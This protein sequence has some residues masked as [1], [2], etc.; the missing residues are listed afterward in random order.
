MPAAVVLAVAGAT[1]ITATIGGAIGAAIVGSTVSTVAATA[2]GTAVLSGT[3]TA[4][5]GGKVSDVLKSAVIGGITSYVGGT[6][7]KDIASDVAFNAISQGVGGQTAVIMGNA[8]GGAAAGA[9]SSGISALIN[10]RD[11][12]QA[13][14]KGGLT[15]GLSSAVNSSV[16]EATK[17]IPILSDPKNA[18]EGAF[19]RATKTAIAT[20][21]LGGNVKNAVTESVITSLG[22]MGFNYIKNAIKDNSAQVQT[23]AN[24]VK[25]A[26]LQLNNNLAAQQ[27][28]AWK[29]DGTLNNTKIPY[30]VAKN[31]ETTYNEAIEA[32]NNFVTDPVAYY[33]QKGAEVYVHPRTNTL[34]YRYPDGY[35]GAVESDRFYL[36]RAVEVSKINAEYYYNEAVKNY[37]AT[38]PKLDEYAAKL[39]ELKN[40]YPGLYDNYKN[41]AGGL[42]QAI[43]DFKAQEVKNSSIALKAM[44]DIAVAKNLFKEQEGREPTDAELA[45]YA[46]N[47]DLVGNI[48]RAKTTSNEAV[49]IWEGIFGTTPTQEEINAIAGLNEASASTTARSIY[50]DRSKVDSTELDDFIR[51]I[52]GGNISYTKDERDSL[53]GM[54]EA[55]A[56]AKI[57]TDYN[58]YITDKQTTDSEELESF[59]Q[60]VTKGQM[61]FTPDQ[62]ME[63]FGLPE[64]VAQSRLTNIYN[65]FVADK[66][67]TDGEEATA[68]WDKSGIDRPM[69]SDELQMMM[70]GSEAAAETYAQR[71]SEI[72]SV[73]PLDDPFANQA[74]AELAAKDAGFKDY[75]Y[76]G[77]TY[78]V[79]NNNI[80]ATVD[81]SLQ[82]EATRLISGA[83]E[84]KGMRLS[85]AAPEEIEQLV[86]SVHA[87]YGN[88]VGRLKA[89]SI[90][91]F[92]N[93][94]A[95]SLDEIQSSYTT[96][97]GFKVEIRG[98]PIGD[99]LSE[100]DIKNEAIKLLPAGLRLATEEETFDSGQ[101]S[102]ITLAN[103]KTAWV[104][105]KP[106]DE[107]PDELDIIAPNLGTLAPDD[108]S[109]ADPAAYIYTL[110]KFDPNKSNL[111]DSILNAAKQ[112]VNLINSSNASPKTRENILDAVAVTLQGTAE[113][114]KLFS[115]AVWATG[116]VNRDN[117]AARIA[118]AVGKY[119]ASLQ[120][121][122]TQKQEEN[123]LKAISDAKGAWN[124]IGAT[125]KA[126]VQNP[127]GALT[128]IGK[129]AVQEIPILA[130]S[131][132]VGRLVLGLGGKALAYSAAMGTSA[133]L[134]A[135]ESF[136]SGYG[137]T[138]DNI[139]KAGGTDEYAKAQAYKSGFQSALVGA[140]SSMLGDSAL[141]KKFMGEM[142]NLTLPTFAKEVTKQYATEWGEEFLTNASTQYN[143]YGTVNWEQAR[144]AGAIGG[145]M[146]AGISGGILAPNAINYQL[147]VAR[148]LQGNP[149]TLQQVVDGTTQVDPNSID[150]AAPVFNIN[151]VGVSIDGFTKVA[152]TAISQPDFSFTSYSNSLK[153][154]YDTGF[155]DSDVS[156]IALQ[157]SIAPDANTLNTQLQS[158][159]LTPVEALTAANIK[160][161]DQVTTQ[162]EVQSEFNQYGYFNP[163]AQTIESFAGVNGDQNLSN[164]IS[165]YVDRNYTD[166]EEVKEAAAREGVTL[167]NE[168]AEQYV[169]QGDQTAAQTS[170]QQAVDPMA[171]NLE[172]ARQ[173]LID[174]GYTPELAEQAASQFVGETP[175]A[176]TTTKAQE[177]V[178]ER[179]ITFE[180]AREYLTSLGYQPT[181]EEVQQFVRVAADPLTEAV[182]QEVGAYVEPRFV[183]EQEVRDAYASLGLQRPTQQ[184]IAKLVGQYAETDLAGKTETNLDAARYNSIIEQLNELSVNANQET[185]DAV[186]AIKNDLNSQLE[187]LGVDVN[188]LTGNVE[189]IRTDLTAAIQAARDAGL[190]GD[191]A[192]QQA[193]ETVA[194]DQNTSKLELLTRL[195]TTEAA[196][197]TQFASEIGAVAAEIGNVEGRLRDAIE[198]AEA[199]GLT[200]DQAIQAGLDAVAS[201]LGTTRNDLLAQLGTSEAALKAQIAQTETSLGE[202]IVNVR[203]QLSDAIA[204]AE[205][206]GLSRDEAIQAGV[207]A[208]ASDLGI[209][210]DTLL[211]QLGT[212]EAALRAEITA[213]QTALGEQ[214]TSGL[215]GVRTDLANAEARINQRAAEYESLGL[216]RDQALNAA[217]SD[218]ASQLGVTARNLEE[219]IFAAQTE[220]S[221]QIT[222]S[223]TALQQQIDQ[224]A[225]IL[226]KPARNVTQADL[227][228]VNSVIQLTPTTYTPEQLVYDVNKDA[229]VDEEDLDILTRIM[230]PTTGEPPV[231]PEGTAF[232]PTGL[233]GEISGLRT[234]I[235]GQLQQMEQRRQQEAAAAEAARQAEATAAAQ[236]AAQAQA[237]AQARAQQQRQYANVQQLQNMLLQPGALTQKVDVRTPD[238]VKLGQLYDWSSIFATPQQQQLYASPYGSYADGGEVTEEEL[239]Q[240]VRG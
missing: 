25:Q 74:A 14:I 143:S 21:I 154:L 185:L 32:Y 126:V 69:T 22:T 109:S 96:E 215:E 196:L 164:A 82:K 95:K 141:V 208:V 147:Q 140:A 187:A 62:K 205:A 93:G 128:L 80:A 77:K 36:Y 175:E 229:R 72:Q 53:L 183:T 195:G 163:D 78:A 110:S 52:S 168:Q 206:A 211:A 98:V 227:D 180:E 6:I 81:G 45:E 209:T 189:Q 213:S 16:Y 49:S 83:L 41:S 1:G 223:Q 37:N 145:L 222:A 240:I 161:D 29:Y 79:N 31:Y 123:I 159:G 91:D 176:E 200:R 167:T 10:E 182:R 124:T 87:M 171:T 100:S 204:A 190:Q 121:A 224:A 231:L 20:G 24:N 166:L 148:D 165:E 125:V 40:A 92:I 67:S 103:G 35:G 50:E 60:N 99:W 144:T 174:A 156:D 139:K 203:T 18:L 89:A 106:A 102:L 90:Q 94:N 158:M 220:L 17:N 192:L 61:S 46:Y 216:S 116:A 4:V 188:Q 236:R 107:L 207:D 111:D 73:T 86:K 59:I 237:T 212:S 199:A 76:N 151:G 214:I 104:M 198:A 179:Q 75:T 19:Q 152:D 13:L 120:S 56:Q 84:A 44:E 228:Y 146:G 157:V 238:V 108:P 39:T 43:E 54:N 218:V 11:P 127:A 130:A 65:E 7:A 225:Q 153:S 181:N 105:N 219:Q 138:Y 172:E 33:A 28:Y 134:D 132:G 226:G 2:I 136:A 70:R 234:D 68:L 230:T 51:T 66:N 210:R 119:G 88:D 9:I 186:Q 38:K 162:K 137:E 64:S 117:A 129:E 34:Y 217:V 155:T 149:V 118:D 184:D 97:G 71:L 12:I 170:I 150:T 15:A 30:D 194:A 57:Q 42:D 135:T 63:F 232:A 115:D 5:Q 122:S 142:T 178:S 58:N 169:Q 221:G 239:L 191:A 233:F 202:Q 177:Y 113:L 55:Q 8:L 173:S 48:D 26:E 197:K 23:Q 131:G 27:D 160:F 193:I 3:M 85:D 201:D 101:A 114:T 235:I 112:V 133:A 47:N